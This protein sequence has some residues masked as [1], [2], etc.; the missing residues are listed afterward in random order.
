MSQ[1]S[2]LAL[3]FFTSASILVMEI[4]AGRLMAPYLGVTIETF[5]GIIGTVL[6]AIAL[7]NW[8]GGRAADRYD[9][10]LLLGPLLIAGGITTILSPTIVAFF[11][12]ELRRAGP[13]EIV[14]LAS[15]GFFLPGAVLAAISPAVVKLR[16]ADLDETGT[17][18]GRFSAVGTA[19]ALVGTFATGFL[20]LATLPTRAILFVVGGA[21]VATGVTLTVRLGRMAPGAMVWILVAA[22]GASALLA[23]VRGPCTRETA[24]FCAIVEPD[25]DRETGTVLW[26]D[27]LRHS[28]IDEDPTHLEFRYAQVFADVLEVVPPAGPL[29]TLSVGGGAMSLPRYVAA[30][31]PGSSATVLELDRTLVDIAID[32]LDAAPDGPLDVRTGDARLTLRSTP[33]AAYDVVFGDAFG[34]PAVPWH[35]TTREFYEAVEERLTPGGFYMMNMIDYPPQAFAR[36]EL[37]TLRAV[38]DHVVVIAPPDYL[39]GDAGGNFVLVASNQPIDTD[40]IGARLEARQARSVALDAAATAAY[41]ADGRV[42]TD[43]FAP[44]DQLISTP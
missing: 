23:I 34:G 39:A 3:V 42:L 28:Y 7:G 19:G 38:F 12:P 4:L 36:A 26:L 25:P 33:T 10:R 32:D 29:N 31:R 30:V 43:D 21:L 14:L 15:L 35:L 20:L 11:G 27:T 24:Y 1:R 5:T 9:P 44:V 17:V 2:A 13:V 8:L 6:A 16:L 40:A 41:S 18:V 37:A 22:T